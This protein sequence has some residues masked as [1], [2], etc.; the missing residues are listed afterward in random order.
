MGSQEESMGQWWVTIGA[1]VHLLKTADEGARTHCGQL[2][3]LDAMVFDQPPA[4]QL[5]ELCRDSFAL[6]AA[7]HA[8]RM[9][10]QDLN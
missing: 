7:E 1:K 3:A 10:R 8:V 9:R 6:D 5:C 2:L 4:G